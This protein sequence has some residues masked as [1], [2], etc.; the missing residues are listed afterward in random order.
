[1]NIKIQ[2]KEF[3]INAHKGQVRK[4]SPAQSYIVHPI[5]VAEILESYGYDDNVVAAGFLHDVVEDTNYSLKDI[6]NIFGSDIASIVDSV[7]EIDKNLSWEE[8]KQKM[9]D[10][11]KSKPFRN[12]LVA[13]SDKIDNIESLTELLKEKG[14]AIF[15]L[16]KRS[17]DK[18]IWYYKNIY[19]SL[20]Y[21]ENENIP[22][23]RRLKDDI[24]LLEKEIKKQIN[25]NT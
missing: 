11:I 19:Q 9:I 21:N 8:R 2:A 10:T 18:Q 7:S 20:I 1:M 5:R 25:T 4:A 3:A 24:V 15:S 22:I 12:K 17:Y 16:F 23:F 14:M 13:C 6:E